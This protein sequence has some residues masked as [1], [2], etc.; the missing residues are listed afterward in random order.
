MNTTN[1][2]KVLILGLILLQA[3][4]PTRVVKP[5]QKG[6]QQVSVHLGG[7]L[8]KFGGAPIPMPLSSV[9]YARG[10][11]DKIT[12]FGS[13]HTT[14]LLFGVIQTDIGICREL[15]SHPAGFGISVNPV[16]NIAVD[17][18][19]G[20]KKLWPELSLN[21]YQSLYQKKLLLYAGS[22][23]WFELASKRAH[24]ET[25]PNRALFHAQLGLQY[26]RKKFSYTL[27]GKYLGMGLP[28][29]PNVVDY[30]GLQN[31]GALG[32]YLGLTRR[33]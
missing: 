8:L 22:S 25:Q 31:K 11:N 30:I 9:A 7:P 15:Y 27:E 4:A 14:A 12:A 29:Q 5:L 10:I 17:T 13:L 19:E 1:P 23:T 3:C 21:A 32:I 24:G 6:E 20:N 26:Q 16:L 18:W 33:F 28:T 2:L